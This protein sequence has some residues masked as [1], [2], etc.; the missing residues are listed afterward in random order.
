M[1]FSDNFYVL[2]SAY[3]TIIGL[4]SPYLLLGVAIIV[5]IEAFVFVNLVD[6]AAAAAAAIVDFIVIELS[7][8]SFEYNFISLT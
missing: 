7:M 4:F 5:I 1:K 8:T 6:L 3:V 2:S